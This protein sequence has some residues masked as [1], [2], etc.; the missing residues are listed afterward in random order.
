MNVVLLRVEGEVD[1]VSE[2][3]Y[4]HFREKDWGGAKKK[5]FIII[6][7]KGQIKWKLK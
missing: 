7:E 2:K 1:F 6:K 3:W 5:K 4:Y